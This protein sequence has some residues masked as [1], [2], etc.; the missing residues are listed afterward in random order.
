MRRVLLAVTGALA[1]AGGCAR[2]TVPSPPGGQPPTPD[3]GVVGSSMVDGA[4]PVLREG[5]P[6]PDRPLPARLTLTRRG[7][8]EVRASAISGP[9]GRFR[10]PLPPGHY[11][12]RAANLTGAVLPA[13]SPFD[14]DV[15]AGHY[16]TVT[17][18][19]DSGV[20]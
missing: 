13:S 19:F 5:T 8:S 18:S 6:C 2:G 1:L 20:R 14:V 9:D 3:S 10:I 12:L 16:T 17:V 7:S 15:Q 4:C 11:I